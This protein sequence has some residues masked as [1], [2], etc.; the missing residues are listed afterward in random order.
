MVGT[1]TPFLPAALAYSRPMLVPVSLEDK[2]LAIQNALIERG[3]KLERFGVDGDFGHETAD[4]VIAELNVSIA[5]PPIPKI[6]LRREDFAY[7]A[8][9]LGCSLPQLRA[10]DEV[11]SGGGWFADMR[12]D[13][14]DLDGPGGFIA[15]PE[16]PKILFE[17]LWFSRF[18]AARFNDT[19]PNISSPRW[20]RALYVGGQAEWGRLHRAMQLDEEAALKSA[21]VGRYQI[22]GFNHDLAG[23]ATVRG[24]WDAMKTN[25]LQHLKAFVRFIKNA[26][27]ADALRN[28]SSSPVDCVAFA[29]GYNGS[30]YRANR[31]HEKIAQAFAKHSRKA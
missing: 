14:L 13:I 10:V 3:R 9:M 30:G 19:H 20:D 12:S 1:L 11:E 29:R 25:E 7:A 6:G 16:L 18:T 24:F 22:M 31:Y 21:S 4:A 15:G 28:V 2:I 8:T 17:A 23:F 26:R 5:A 27:L